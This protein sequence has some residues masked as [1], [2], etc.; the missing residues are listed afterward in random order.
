[1]CVVVGHGVWQ[2]IMCKRKSI[3]LVFLD[4]FFFFGSQRFIFQ[5]GY[6][7]FII[8]SSQQPLWRWSRCDWTFF[9]SSHALLDIL[10][11]QTLI[12]SLS[13]R[14][15]SKMTTYIS[16]ENKVVCSEWSFTGLEQIAEL[17]LE[18][19]AMFIWVSCL[20]GFHTEGAAMAS[21]HSGGRRL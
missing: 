9:S 19:G 16:Q 5:F 8:F 17:C 15:L 20:P 10:R 11:H 2:N 13:S 6:R 18:L 3:F 7:A 21:K 12:A 14:N 1:M 4:P